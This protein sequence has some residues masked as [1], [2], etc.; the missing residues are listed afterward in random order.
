[1]AISLGCG[2]LTYISA[3]SARD[4]SRRGCWRSCGTVR[5][6]RLSCHGSGGC[7]LRGGGGI[8]GRS[9]LLRSRGGGSSAG[10]RRYTCAPGLR[11]LEGRL[12]FVG[13]TSRVGAV[14]DAEDEVLIRAEAFISDR[15]TARRC[16]HVVDAILLQ[17]KVSRWFLPCQLTLAQ[18]SLNCGHGNE[19]RAD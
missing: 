9:S 14:S 5:S 3:G 17:A 18:Q 19:S 13:S 7:R 2:A 1:M 6:C 12:C 15:D 10:R 8:P 16:A 11:P 4:L